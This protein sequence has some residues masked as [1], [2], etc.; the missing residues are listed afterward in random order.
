MRVAVERIKYEGLTSSEDIEAKSWEMDSFDV[1]FVKNIH[2]DCRFVRAGKEI[3]VE[4]RV[5]THRLITCSRCLEQVEQTVEQDFKLSYR[6]ADLGDYLEIDKDV[7][8]EILLDFPMK[9]LCRPDCKG[10]CPG[11]GV[12]LNYEKCRCNK[13]NKMEG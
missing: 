1:H 5:V 4:A 2:L 11:C 6:V 7:R 13:K 8:E 9:V 3:L 10:I 12:N